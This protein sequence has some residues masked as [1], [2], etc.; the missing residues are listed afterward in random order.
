MELHSLQDK[1]ARG[2]TDFGAEEHRLREKRQM[3]AAAYR[4]AV[5]ELGRVVEEAAGMLAG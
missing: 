4:A 2:V 3:V 5:R 1:V